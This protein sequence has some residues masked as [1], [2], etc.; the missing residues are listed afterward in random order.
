MN[1]T[2]MPCSPSVVADQNRG[3]WRQRLEPIPKIATSG[4]DRDGDGDGRDALGHDLR[5]QPVDNRSRSAAKIF[6]SG[7][8]KAKRAMT[9]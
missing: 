4:Q 7:T 6:L 9:Q 5:P 8:A 3:P 2:S 1:E